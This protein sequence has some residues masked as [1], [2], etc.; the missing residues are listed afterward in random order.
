MVR[1]H[2]VPGLAPRRRPRSPRVPRISPITI[3]SGSWRRIYFKAVPTSGCHSHFAL[4]N[5][6]DFLS[7]DVLNG[8]FNRD[9]IVGEMFVEVVDHR[10]ERGGFSAPGD[11]GDENK[12]GRH[13]AELLGVSGR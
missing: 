1:E 11:P 4:R 8:V 5:P 10:V 12:S 2:E 13:P 6:N 7:C 9:D 3:T